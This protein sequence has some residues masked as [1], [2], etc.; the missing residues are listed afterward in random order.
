MWVVE[1]GCVETQ[2]REELIAQ[3]AQLLA[4]NALL[5]EK[6]AALKAESSATS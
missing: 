1:V 3:N 6:F 2:T 5:K 4:A